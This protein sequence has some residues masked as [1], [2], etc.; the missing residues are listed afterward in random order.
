ML[1]LLTRLK[2]GGTPIHALGT[3]SHLMAGRYGVDKPALRDFLRKVADLGLEIIVSELD[4]PDRYLP[5]DPA[6]RDAAIAQACHDL[7]EV[8]LAEPAVKT[9]ITWG[10]T[11]KYSWLSQDDD[12]KRLDNLPSRGSPFDDA[13]KPKPAYAALAQAFDAAAGR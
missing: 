4:V 11:D 3:Q 6:R 8:A 13:L 1:D 10:L 9:V 5:A 12:V 2:Q 7:L